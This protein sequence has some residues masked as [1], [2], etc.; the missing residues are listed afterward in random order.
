MDKKLIRGWYL[1]SPEA[2]SRYLVS[3]FRNWGFPVFWNLSWDSESVYQKV[4]LGTREAPRAL[5][6]RI[7]DHSVSQKNLWVAFNFDVYCGYEREG[8]ISYIKLLSIL[9][10]KLDKPLPPVLEQLKTGTESYKNY[11]IEMQRRKRQTNS[12]CRSFESERLYV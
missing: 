1:T 5:H 12:R 7:S 6:I 3:I 9:A 10:E 4:C 11:R 2:I 8:A